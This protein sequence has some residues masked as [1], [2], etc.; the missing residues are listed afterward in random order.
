MSLELPYNVKVLNPNPADF[1]VGPFYTV[2]QALIE[3]TPG[4]RVQGLPTIIITAGKP[5]LY[6]FE[7]G[8]ADADFVTYI[9]DGAYGSALAFQSSKAVSA[10]LFY[11]TIQNIGYIPGNAAYQNIVGGDDATAVIGNILKPFKTIGAAIAAL[12]VLPNSALVCAAGYNFLDDTNSPYGLKAPNSF[13]DVFLDSGC[14]VDYYGTYGIYIS[15]NTTFGN[16]FGRGVAI[17]NGSIFTG[18]IDGVNNYAFNVQAY[19][20]PK[21]F[22]LYDLKRVD[23]SNAANLLRIGNCYQTGCSFDISGR[24]SESG[25]WC[26]TCDT[27]SRTYFE[28][29]NYLINNSNLCGLLRIIDVT[30]FALNNVYQ[31]AAYGNWVSLNQT[32]AIQI[33]DNTLQSNISFNSCELY[34]SLTNNPNYKLI[35]FLT[36]G[37]L[38]NLL[39]KRCT[40]KNR[41]T[42]AFSVAGYSFY[43]ATN[44]SF[45]IVDT[46]AQRDIGGAGTITNLISKGNGFMVEPNL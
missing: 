46:Y 18:S 9:I 43:S 22:Q 5:V 36:G 37:V 20:T 8:I 10:S 32:S 4:I 28:K 34:A 24:I 1:K 14:V 17:A 27:G 45:K 39:F 38:P 40:L 6:W 11:N 16:I 41:Q 42:N 2:A 12:G 3:N 13:Y 35:E 29:I 44:V 33:T 21:F 15:N 26:I 25:G 19:Q 30:N 7:N 31:S 23:T